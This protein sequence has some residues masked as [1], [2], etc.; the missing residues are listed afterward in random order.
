[1]TNGSSAAATSQRTRWSRCSVPALTTTKKIKRRCSS[2]A[3]PELQMSSPTS[4]TPPLLH[5]VLGL[6]SA[7]PVPRQPA[8]TGSPR[9]RRDLARCVVGDHE[10]GSGATVRETLDGRLTALYIRARPRS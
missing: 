5:H 10:L 8:R 1:M 2:S 3:P 4:S 6:D 9:Q 7:Q